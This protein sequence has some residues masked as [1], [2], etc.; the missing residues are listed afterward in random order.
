MSPAPIEQLARTTVRTLPPYNAGLSSAEVR[1]R[2]GVEHVARLGSNE[3]PY[4][5][6]PAVRSAA[7]HRPVRMDEI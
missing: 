1:A 3:N 2:Y 4:G 5:A 7:E 6:S